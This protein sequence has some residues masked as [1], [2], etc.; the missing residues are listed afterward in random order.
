[1]QYL[2]NP[3]SLEEAF[4]NALNSVLGGTGSGV[5]PRA[6]FH[7]KFQREVEEHDQD[8][9]KKYDEDLNT[10]L[11]FVSITL[12]MSSEKYPESDVCRTVSRSPVYSRQWRLHSSSISKP[13]SAQITSN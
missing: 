11:I 8:L 13:G 9:E 3:Q 5:N 6:T 4:G 10:A 2:I 1:M 12:S 7:N